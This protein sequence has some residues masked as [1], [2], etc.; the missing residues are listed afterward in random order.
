VE[1]LGF[2]VLL[3][4][5]VAFILSMGRPLKVALS[6]LWRPSKVMEGL[7]VGSGASIIIWAATGFS[8]VTFG[9]CHV[10]CGGSTWEIGKF[11]EA[12]YGGFV[13][14]YLYVRYG[15]HV[16]VLAHWGIDF[17]GSVY[18][19]FGQ[20]AFGTPWNS[21]TTEFWGQYLVDL[22]MLFLFGL[23]SFLVVVYLGARKLAQWR[24]EQQRGDFKTLLEGAGV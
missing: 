6:T 22:D 16:A 14:G 8:A 12:A 21:S 24:S 20:A 11:P 1:E 9:A 10:I 7:A 15:F 18:S 2:R 19:F 3:I 4:G 13:L 23:A 17:F 5:L